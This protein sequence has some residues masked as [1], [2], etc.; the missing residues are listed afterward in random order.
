MYVG[1]NIFGVYGQN[2]QTLILI[3]HKMLTN[4]C[5]L[6]NQTKFKKKTIIIQVENCIAMKTLKTKTIENL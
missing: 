2:K 6:T 3:V 1:L 5:Y 4:S